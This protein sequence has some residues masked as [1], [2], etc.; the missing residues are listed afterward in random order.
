MD[1]ELHDF[2]NSLLCESI[3][4]KCFIE[5]DTEP[6]NKKKLSIVYA[7]ICDCELRAVRSWHS[8]WSRRLWTVL[9]PPFLSFSLSFAFLLH[10]A[11]LFSQPHAR[12]GQA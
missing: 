9:S 3:E 4:R 1:T 2:S 11:F 12:P 5:K 7:G 6:C 10:T 8:L